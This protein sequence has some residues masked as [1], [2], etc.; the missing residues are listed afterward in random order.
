M[1][2]PSQPSAA[3]IRPMTAPQA[4]LKPGSRAM[5]ARTRRAVWGLG[6]FLSV[7]VA[8]FSYRYLPEL[9]HRPPN[10]LGNT[11]A[12]PWLKVHVAGAATALLLG[13]FN[14][15]SAIRRRTPSV[16]R[17]VG[18]IY[19]L[20]CFVGSAGGLVIAFGSFAGPIATVGFVSLAVSWIVANVQG[21]RSAVDGRFADHREWMIRSFAMTFGAVLLRVYLPLSQLLH[22]PFIDAY[23]AIAF[24]AWVPNLVVAEI[25]LRRTRGRGHAPRKAPTLVPAAP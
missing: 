1:N 2:T 8:L 13:P 25:Y 24:L 12:K 20:G 18:R 22:I 5:S 11:F 21:W 23:R 15:V 14:F 6:A 10:I 17:W 7:G 9:G 19:L 3:D 4:R 16:H